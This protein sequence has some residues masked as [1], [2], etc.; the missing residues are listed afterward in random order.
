[1][2]V[3]TDLLQYPGKYSFFVHFKITALYLTKYVQV[4]AN[5]ERI[6]GKVKKGFT[7]K[8]LKHFYI[9]FGEGW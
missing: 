2:L 4:F 3:N 1:M 7:Y 6:S 9:I 5:L 8:N